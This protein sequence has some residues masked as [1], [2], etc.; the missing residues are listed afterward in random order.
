MSTVTKQAVLSTTNNQRYGYSFD[1]IY[2]TMLK[3]QIFRDYIKYY[4]PG[5]G[6]L[7]WK[8]LM[9]ETVNIAGSSTIVWEE[10]SYTKL[11]KLNGAIAVAAAGADITFSL[12]AAEYDAN[13]ACY[14]NTNEIIV[15]PAEYIE[16]G[17]VPATIPHGYQVTGNDGGVDAARIYTARPLLVTTELAVAVPDDTE[18]LVS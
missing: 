2:N 8:Y 18:L 4:G 14:L 13:H 15:I 9:G 11:V 1:S 3:P 6:V 16:E 12:D 17:G 5:I 10:G 7:G